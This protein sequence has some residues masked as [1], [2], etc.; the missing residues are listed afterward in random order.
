MLTVTMYDERLR[1]RGQL[2]APKV[3]AVIR[4]NQPAT[5]VIDVAVESQ[6]AAARIREGW[7]IS[8]RDGALEESGPVTGF[9]R[10]AKGRDIEVEINCAS[11]LCLIGDRITYP[12]PG[13]AE[14]LQQ[15]ARYR[16]SGTGETVIKNLVEANAGGAAIQSRRVPLLSVAADKGRGSTASVD[17][18]LKNLLEVAADLANSCGLI[19]RCGLENSRIVFDTV[20]VQ[21]LS[22]R[23]RL[24]Y[25]TGEVAGW[26]MKDSVGTATAVVVGGQGE[27]SDRTITSVAR[28]DVWGR[29]IEVFKDRRDT[30]SAAALEKSAKEE[31]DKGSADKTLKL[32]LHESQARRFGEDFRVGDTITLDLAPGV[33]PYAAPVVEAKIMWE[34]STRTVE[35]TVGDID[36]SVS[37]ERMNRIRRELSQLSTI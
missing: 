30:D 20:P 17:T 7:W 25:L 26:E 34:S 10:T 13:R 32:V 16:R 27:G 22:R 24:S 33:S 19:M 15:V 11:A 35:L 23:V 5:F 6:A 9:H 29:R 8:I 21:N 3:E 28:S 14:N 1:P 2:V 4:K 36:K 18:R 12:D 31:L 37:G